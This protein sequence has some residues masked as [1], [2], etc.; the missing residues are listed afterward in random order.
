MRA[1]CSLE[2]FCESILTISRGKLKQTEALA[3]YSMFRARIYFACGMMSRLN[4]SVGEAGCHAAKWRD[5]KLFENEL[6]GAYRIGCI[7]H[8]RFI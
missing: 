5:G 6:A 3:S 4:I 7:E 1:F 2:V 8:L